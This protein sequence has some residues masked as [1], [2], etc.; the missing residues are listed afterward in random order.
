VDEAPHRRLAQVQVRAG[1]QRFRFSVLKQYGCKCA[2]CSITHPQLVHAAHIRSKADRG[3]DDWRNGLPLC[4]THHAAFDAHLFWI[5]PGSLL[6]HFAP[7]VSPTT[8]GVS[9]GRL[10]VLKNAPHEAAITWKA[11]VARSRHSLDC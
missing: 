6:L 3:T 8:I 5:E 10:D 2:V 11:G 1:Q 9:S 7:G 4:S